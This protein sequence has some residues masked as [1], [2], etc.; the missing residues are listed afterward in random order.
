MSSEDPYGSAR[1]E[2]SQLLQLQDRMLETLKDI[3]EQ[4]AHP[5]TQ[6][7]V[8]VFRRAEGGGDNMSKALAAVESAI[9][10]VKVSESE[11]RKALTD[12]GEGDA[13]GPEGL[14]D[15]PAPLARFL[16]SRAE[17]PGFRYEVIQ[18]P[19]RGW[20]I[21]WK[22]FTEFGTVRGHGQFYERPYAYLDD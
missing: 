22:E 1:R 12:E 10:D 13:P 6:G 17:T 20:I 5:Q 21:R 8:R 7:L 19:V 9:R 18:D 11:V 15:L 2:L 4:L 3:K 14:P 16:A